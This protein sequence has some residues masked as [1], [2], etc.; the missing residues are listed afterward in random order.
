LAI[1]PAYKDALVMRGHLYYNEFKNYKAALADYE[2]LG[3][4]DPQNEEYK[5]FIKGAR[6]K[7]KE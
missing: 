1:D 7:L 3:K 6:E 2:A 4:L 5:G